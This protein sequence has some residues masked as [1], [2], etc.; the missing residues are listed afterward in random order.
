MKQ[1]TLIAT[2]FLCACASTPA[3][4]KDANNGNDPVDG[5]TD[6][7]LSDAGFEPNDGLTPEQRTLLMQRPY[8]AV[9]S[10]KYDGGTAVPLLLLLHG[11][12]GPGVFQDA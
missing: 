2:V 1:T 10:S 3:G 11:Y 6:A 5:G 7:G 4:G 12:G 8:R 9:V